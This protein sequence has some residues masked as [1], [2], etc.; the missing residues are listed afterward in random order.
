MIGLV[1]LKLVLHVAAVRGDGYFRDELY[2][3][4]LPNG[5]RFRPLGWVYVTTL[6]IL[7]AAGTSRANY[8]APAYPMLFAAGR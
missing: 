8:L 4:V 7:V 3:L 5:R 1:L 2:Y 6:L